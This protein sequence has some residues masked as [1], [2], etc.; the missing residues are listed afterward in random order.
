MVICNSEKGK[1]VFNKAK[2]YMFGH[3]LV[4]EEAFKYQSPPRK[5][6]DSKPSRELF[7][8]DSKS[9]LSC[10]EPNKKWA[11]KPMFKLLWQKYIWGNR[12][13]VALWRFLHGKE[14]HDD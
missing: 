14:K 9:N 13:K 11:K 10:Y 12:Q 1:S 6:I 3:D 8:A 7:M 2:E 4:F 5:H